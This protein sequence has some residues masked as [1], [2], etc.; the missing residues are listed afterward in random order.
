MKIEFKRIISGLFALSLLAAVYGSTTLGCGGGAGSTAALTP[1]AGPQ[2][3]VIHYIDDHLGSAHLI[4]DSKG[5]VLR[6]EN[7]YPYGLDWRV[8]GA[9]AT[10]ADYVY[11]GKEY[12]TETGLVYFGGRYYS[13]EMGRWITPDPAF[14]ENPGLAAKR[15]LENNLYSYVASNPVNLVDPNGQFAFAPLIAI[16]LMT[17]AY[18][19]TDENVANAPGPHDQLVSNPTFG[20]RAER[21][22]MDAVV[23]YLGLRV[24]GYGFSLMR[25]SGAVAAETVA[26]KAPVAI[27]STPLKE[28]CISIYH[29]SINDYTRIMSGG[30]NPLKGA[31]ATRDINAARNA[32]SV[33][34]YEITQG[35][36]TDTGIIESS[37]PYSEYDRVLRPA[38][39]AYEYGWGS[40]YGVKLDSTQII[41]DTPEQIATFNKYIVRD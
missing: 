20:E 39:K 17:A 14:F 5:N 2:K 4:T 10:T 3:G 19:M 18:V 36:A 22:V 11:T 34:R 6:E 37:V 27:E 23:G 8:D 9:D 21:H 35:I 40:E 16:G 25:G 30:L 26:S 33:F 24:V 38:E 28:R 12:D 7:R 41:M 31:Y 29:G 13:P 32:V 1:D 15:P